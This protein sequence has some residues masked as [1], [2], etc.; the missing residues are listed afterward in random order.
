MFF[1]AVGILI[2][3]MFLALVNLSLRYL[4]TI[5]LCGARTRRVT[6]LLH[7]ISGTII[8]TV[9]IVM[10]II[11]IRYYSWRLLWGESLHSSFGLTILFVTFFAAVLGFL[12]W[13]ASFQPKTTTG[14]FLNLIHT[15]KVKQIHGLLGYGLVL[16]S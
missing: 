4:K 3:N 16:T 7:I 15:M 13:F 12:S 5:N 8:T 11:A 10:S 2:I 6:M 14:G 1:Y 9:T